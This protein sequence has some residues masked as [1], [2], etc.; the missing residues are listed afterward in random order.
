GDHMTDISADQLDA[1]GT[2]SRA[3]VVT[4]EP[5][6]RSPRITSGDGTHVVTYDRDS[7]TAANVDNDIAANASGVDTATDV[8]AEPARLDAAPEPAAA[9]HSVAG[10]VHVS[11]RHALLA[12]LA[13]F[14]VW[15][16]LDAPTLLHSAQAGPLGT[17]RTVAITVLRPVAAVSDALG[18]SHVV[19]GAD[20][21]IGHTGKATSGVLAV[22][23]RPLHPHRGALRHHSVRAPAPQAPQPTTAVTPV[24]APD[25]LAPLAA[26]TASAPLRL[27]V[28]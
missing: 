25:G 21:V 18:L 17:R 16:V 11:W 6:E 14:V 12:R 9:P 7:G 4:E 8:R 19:A 3:P 26:P 22:E 20:R 5:G 15:L 28:V 27:L 13:C 1:P 23:G 2:G 24:T 10:R